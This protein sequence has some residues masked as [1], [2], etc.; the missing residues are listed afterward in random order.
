MTNVSILLSGPIGLRLLKN[1]KKQNLRA[2]SI[3]IDKNSKKSYVKEV[4][5]IKDHL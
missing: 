2:D 1:F 4:K 3:I 5:K